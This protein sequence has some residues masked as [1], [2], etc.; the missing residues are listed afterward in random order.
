MPTTRPTMIEVAKRGAEFVRNGGV[1]VVLG[2]LVL[3]FVVSCALNPAWIYNTIGLKDEWAYFGT[4]LNPVHMRKVYPAH[5]AGDLLPLILTG[6]AYYHLFPAFWAN[7]FLKMTYFVVAGFVMFEILKMEF[8]VRTA[9]LGTAAFLA[10]KELLFAIGSDYPLGMVCVLQTCILYFTLRAAALE[11]PRARGNLFC[12]GFLYSMSVFTALLSL[13]YLPA[14]FVLYCGKSW[15]IRKSFA[16]DWVQRCGAF[17][18]GAI[19]G[20]LAL[21]LIHHAYTGHFIFFANTLNK[22]RTFLL[23]KPHQKPFSLRNDW[24]TLPI[25]A[26]LAAAVS[27]GWAW[28]AHRKTLR[29]L[30]ESRSALMVAGA[31]GAYA[32]L[33]YVEFKKKTGTISDPFYFDQTL[34][35]TYLALSGLLFRG[36]ESIPR[37]TFFT[38]VLLFIVGSFFLFWMSTYFESYRFRISARDVRVFLIVCAS[39]SLALWLSYFRPRRQRL[40]TK[41]VSVL[42]FARA[43]IAFVKRRRAVALVGLLLALFSIVNFSSLS[44]QRIRQF[45]GTN[46][47]ITSRKLAF[48]LTADWVR[49]MNRLD[50]EREAYLWYDASGNCD[51]WSALAAASHYWQGRVFNEQFPVANAPIGEMGIIE[52]SRLWG[53]R[54]LIMSSR[55]DL[56][57]DARENLRKLGSRID[58]TG[59]QVFYSAGDNYF[60]VQI[61]TF[62]PL[63]GP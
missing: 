10:S 16:R 51:H 60:S 11:S 47:L 45:S 20:F 23:E 26:L 59:I 13:V 36:C 62:A 57:D 30:L 54:I 56:M 33:A 50:P 46:A 61:C 37:K 6:G 8:S 27:C 25:C 41:P 55:E 38:T 12:A 44:N 1:P 42:G 39:L 4:F 32:A 5:P 29:G 58:Y 52:P 31:M 40:A 53:R 18:L 49:L 15:Q 43:T 22:A 3:S 7:F 14:I 2:I 19:L 34:P 17:A 28:F 63:G 9:I 21:C 48:D 24:L 35:F